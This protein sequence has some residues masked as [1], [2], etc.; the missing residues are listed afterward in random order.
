MLIE[1]VYQKGLYMTG[2]AVDIKQRLAE[3]ATKYTT[4]KELL[5]D[6]TPR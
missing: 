3:H 4:V 6:M 5:A 2:K 1:I